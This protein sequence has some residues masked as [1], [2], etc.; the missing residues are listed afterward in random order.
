MTP[1]PNEGYFYRW[2]G[3]SLAA[4]TL[5]SLFLLLLPKAKTRGRG[6]WSESKEDRR[7]PSNSKV[8]SSR[9]HGKVVNSCPQIGFLG[10]KILTL[11][12]RD[13]R[14]SLKTK[15]LPQESP[16]NNQSPHLTSLL[17][18][19]HSTFD[20]SRV[21]GKW[22]WCLLTKFRPILQS[23]P[24]NLANWQ[25]FIISYSINSRTWFLGA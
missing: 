18:S 19:K 1:A 24:S 7:L 20:V 16:K 3:Q 8:T 5:E 23:W 13:R 14:A 4:L 17:M 9:Q 2:T 21:D 12:S 15:K 6:W 25:S 11:A 22:L 10:P